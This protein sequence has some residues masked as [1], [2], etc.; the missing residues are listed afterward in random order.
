MT[1]EI[2][3]IAG[4]GS[5]I[6]HRRAVPAEDMMQAFLYRHWVPAQQLVVRVSEP[7]PVTVNLSVPKDGIFYARPGSEITINSAVKWNN[8]KAQKSIKLTLADPP[9]WLTL[10]TGNVG[11]QGGRIVLAV[12]PNAEL[13]NKATVLLNGNIRT[14]T[15]DK[16]NGFNPVMKFMN[17]K[18]LDFTIDA[19]SIEVMN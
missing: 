5:R 2:E 13:G 18:T 8:Q 11:G 9:E 12:S 3:G 10:K 1:L 15:S 4:C 19:V 14:V 16:D 6:V 17:T 7:A